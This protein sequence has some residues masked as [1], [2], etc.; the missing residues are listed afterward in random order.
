MSLITEKRLLKVDPI[1]LTSD[2][3]V[4]GGLAVPNSSVFRVGQIIFLR[5]D[6]VE[7][8]EF[9]IKRIDPIDHTTIWVGPD[10]KHISI[11]SDIS[12]YTVA[13]NAV[14]YANEQ[15]RPSVPEQEIERLTY[16]TEP[17]V[18]RRVVL[19]DPWGCRIDDDNPLPVSGNITIGDSA[20]NPTIF[21][22]NATLSDTEYSQALPNGTTQFSIKARNNAKLQI[23]YTLGQTNT[24]FLTITPGNI[25]VV[26]SVKLTNKTLYFRSTKNDTVVEIVTWN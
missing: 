7:P 20:A 25:Y 3:T 17:T 24:S 4:S 16:E 9:K 12:A 11:R 5:S 15:E 1:A 21:N 23:S 19:V 18:A 8:Q 13:D 14:I 2:G 10:R 26:K 22:I 6:T